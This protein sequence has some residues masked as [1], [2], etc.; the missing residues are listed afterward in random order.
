MNNNLIHQQNIFSA[1]KSFVQIQEPRT[2]LLD[3]LKLLITNPLI[4]H[5]PFIAIFL[6][7]V[8]PSQ[9]Y[10]ALVER[11]LI[12][13]LEEFL[14]KSAVKQFDAVGPNGE[15]CEIKYSQSQKKNKNLF[16]LAQLSENTT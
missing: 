9:S 16:M 14:N 6:N 3:E 8:L 13:T 5:N 7:Q 2:K 10:G 4:K 11:V 12:N 1:I 15:R